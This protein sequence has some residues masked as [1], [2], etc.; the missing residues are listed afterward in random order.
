M[1]RGGGH[2]RVGNTWPVPESRRKR[3]TKQPRTAR[4]YFSQYIHVGSRGTRTGEPIDELPG[5]RWV[6][7]PGSGC[8]GGATR[9]GSGGDDCGQ[10]DCQRDG[11]S[12]CPAKRSGQ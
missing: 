12:D 10:S 2:V 5:C 4:G 3:G 1:E 11:Q 8:I 6:Q 7:K 9:F